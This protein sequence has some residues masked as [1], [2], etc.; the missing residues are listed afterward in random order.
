MYTVTL[1]IPQSTDVGVSVILNI[2]RISEDL[3]KA[4]IKA[5]GM[6]ACQARCLNCNK[7]ACH[8]GKSR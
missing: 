3:K 8:A 5:M 6:S 7:C 4:A 2:N 1:S